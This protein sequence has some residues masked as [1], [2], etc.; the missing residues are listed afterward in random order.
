MLQI[1]EEISVVGSCAAEGKIGMDRKYATQ[2]ELWLYL[3]KD[4]IE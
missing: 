2:I 4:C 1:Q 3:E